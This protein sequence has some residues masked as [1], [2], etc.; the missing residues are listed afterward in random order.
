LNTAKRKQFYTISKT[1]VLISRL[2]KLSVTIFIY[3]FYVGGLTNHFYNY[4]AEIA[5]VQIYRTRLASLQTYYL[6]RMKTCL[7]Q[8]SLKCN[9]PNI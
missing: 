5:S 1:N 3:A 2:F 6:P 9:G 8:P 4:F 7:G